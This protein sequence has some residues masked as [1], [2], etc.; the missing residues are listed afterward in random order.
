MTLQME[1][2]TIQENNLSRNNVQIKKLFEKNYSVHTFGN[3]DSELHE[4][5]IRENMVL[6]CKGGFYNYH[7][8][9]EN[10]AIKFNRSYLN[11]I[12][13]SGENSDSNMM[14]FSSNKM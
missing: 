12:C 13:K 9:D 6:M 14:K 10:I 3:E 8:L 4:K 1:N 11:Q 5:E 7:N 2:F